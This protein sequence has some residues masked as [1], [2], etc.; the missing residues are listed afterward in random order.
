MCAHVY[1]LEFSCVL[2]C[3]GYHVL[4]GAQTCVTLF[5]M[6]HSNVMPHD[7]FLAF[8][9]LGRYHLC[10]ALTVSVV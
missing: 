8:L 1:S 7:F 9:A 6:L 10:I 4:R 3:A 2:L 5:L